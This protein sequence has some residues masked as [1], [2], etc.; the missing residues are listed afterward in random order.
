MSGLSR[1]GLL[2]GA[3]A[4]LVGGTTVGTTVGTATAAGTGTGRAPVAVLPGDPRYPELVVGNNQRWVGTPDE[5]RL[6]RTTEEVVRAV[7]D[8]VRAGARIAVRSGGHCYEDFVA[9]PDVRIVLDLSGLRDVRYDE[10]H[11]AFSIGPGATLLQAYEALYENWGVTIPGGT[12]YSVGVGGHVVGGGYGLLSRRF[13][14]TVDHLH[15]VE[16]VVV[17]ATGTARA[18]VA[19]R[20]RN[21]DLWWAHTGGGGGNFGVVTRYLMRTPGTAAAAPAAQL[22]SPPSH[23]VVATAAF[24]WDGLDEAGFATLLANFGRW[25]EAN[26]AP[27]SAGTA[28]SANALLRH[29]SAGHVGVVVQVDADAEPLLGEFLTALGRDVGVAPTVP[30]PRR[31]PWLRATRH[32]GTDTPFLVDPTLRAEHKAAYMRRSF[33]ADHV[34]AL[35]RHLVRADYDN[36]DAMVVLLGFG[37]QVNAVGPTDT[38]VAQ[39]DSVFKVLYQSFWR[40]QEE[41][42]R[43][44]RWV[45]EVYRD[46]YAATGGVP[47]P[48]PVTDGC[49]VNYPDTDLGDPAFNTSGVPWHDL[50][51]KQNYP[52]LQRVKAAWDPRDVFRHAQSIRL[53]AP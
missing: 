32:L 7:D 6:P 51:Y 44:V 21:R 49:Y 19:T 47:V 43:H 27:G 14:L 36:P 48:G 9:N 20:E 13:G 1:R 11:R 34:A 26:S 33:P 4:A 10:E 37:G 53:P 50:Y 31:L 12:C 24:P 22:P 8:A 40:D 45:R 42:E 5:I 35:H 15:G 29:R 30:R 52:R 46:V 16:V 2:A 17:D 28:L 41:D 18:V 23:V 39:R 25:H 38:A 3:G